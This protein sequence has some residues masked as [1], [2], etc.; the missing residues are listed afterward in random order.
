MKKTRKSALLL[1]LILTLA[2]LIMPFGTTNVFAE[3]NSDTFVTATTSTSVKQGNSGYCYV[4]IDSLEALSTLS[5]TVHYDADKVS[6]QSGYVYNT[7]SS[8]L[9]DK[10]VSESS[11]QFSYIFDGKGQNTKTQLFYFRYTVLSDSE[12]G[13]TYF[14]IVVNEAYDSSL[15][16]ITIS[17]SRCAFQIAET[18]T[19]KS[20]SA[21]SSWSVDTAVGEEFELSYSL[22]TYQIAS[23]AFSI[24]YDP[25]LFEVVGVTNGAFCNNKIVDVN[26]EL[27]GSVYVSFVGTEYNYGYDLLKVKFKTLKNVAEKSTIKMTVT[28]FYDLDLNL[29]SCSGYTTT[30]NVAFDEAYTENAPSMT[31]QTAYNAAT[32]KVTLT[33]KL[34]KDSMLGAGDFVLKFDTNY[35]TYNSAEK[36]FS[37]TFFNINDKNVSDG[38]LKFSIIS[39]SNITEEQVVL[40]V[41]FDVNHACEDKVAEFEISG[42]GLTDA[43]TN[44]IM[45]NFVDANVT[46]PLKHIGATAVVENRLE[47]TCTVD[48]RY[49]RVVY[50][51][52]C[53]TELERETNKI[54]KLGHNHST[55]WTVDIEPT[56][57]D[58]GSKSHHCS[59]C[60]NRAEV[61]AIPANGHSFGDWYTIK[62]PTCT[63]TGTDEHKCSV[64]QHTETKTT[65]AYGHTPA[66]AVVE[67]RVE[68][69]CTTNGSYDSVV[70][71]SVCKVELSREAKIINKLGHNYSTE[72]TVDI[73]PTCTTVGSKSHHCERCEDKIDIT[74]IPAKGHSFGDWYTVKA[75]TCTETGTDEHKCSVCQHTETKTTNAHGHTPANATVENIVMPSCTTNG[76][77]DSAIYCSVCNIE[78]SRETKSLNKLGHDYKTEWTVDV[79]P[80]CTT[81]GIK[82]HHCSRCEDKIDITVISANGH[83]YG[84][85]Y[86]I[87]VPT[88][89]ST[90]VDEHECS[91]CH[92]KE[93]KT[94]NALGHTPGTE[95]EEN[96]VEPTCTLNGSYD[97]VVYCSVCNSELSRKAKTINKLGH[98]YSAEWTIDEHPTC[99]TTGIKSHHCSRCD[100]QTDITVIPANGHA[101]GDWYTITLPTCASTGIDEHECSVCHSKETKTTNALGHTPADAVVENRVEPDCT[102][103]GHYES[104]VYCAV[105]NAELSRETKTL[106]KLGHNY[107]TEWTVDVK[108]TCTTTGIKSH[109]CSRCN[110]QTDM[111]VIPANGHSYGDWYVTQQSTEN[112]QGEKRRDCSNCSSYETS[113]IAVL[114]HD[115]SRWETIILEAQAPTCTLS[116]LTQ[117]SKCSKCGEILISQNTIPANGHEYGD[118]YETKAPTCITS[119]TNE[120]E[121]SV[122][123]NKETKTTNAFGHTPADAVVKN[124]VE[125]DCTTNGSYDSVVYCSVCNIELAREVKT[126]PMLGHNYSD[127]WEIDVEATCTATGSKSHH[128]TRCGDK[129][130]V[131]VIPANGHKYG[132]WYE[133]LA[134][135]C[136]TTGTNEREC[137]VCHNKETMTVNALGHT[138]AEAVVENRVK[139]DC[140]AN[141]SYDS[142]VYCSVCNAELSREVKTIPMLGHDYSDKWEIDVEA[143]CTATGS[144]SHHC[145][146][147]GDKADVTVIPANGHKYGDWYE[148][149]VPTCT[150]TGTNE[151]ECSVCHNKETKTVNALG[152]TPADAV[153]KNRVE[154]D[155]TTNG[156]YDSVVYCSVCNVELS[157]E[158]KTIPMLGHNYSEEWEIDVEAT[159]T[160]TGSKSHHCSRCDDK[161]DVTVIPANGHKYGDWRETLAPTCTTTGTNERECSVC[162]DKETKMVNALGHTPAD[163]IVENRVEADCT[164]NGHYDSVVY[165]SVCNAELSREVKTIPMLGHNYSDEWTQDS[166]PTCTDVGSKSHHCLRCDDKVDVTEVPKL[167]HAY[168]D[169]YETLA[170][171]C[172]TTGTEEHKCSVCQ[173]TEIKTTNALGHTESTAVTENRIEPTCTDNGSYDSVVYCLVCDEE[174]SREQKSID[175]LGHDYSDEWTVDTEPTCTAIGSKSHHCSRCDDKSDVTEISAIGHTY[176]DDSDATCN[177]CGDEREIETTVT[178]E[179]T[180]EEIT[181]DITEDTTQNVETE[182]TSAVEDTTQD[183]ETEDASSAEDATQGVGTEDTS[184]VETITQDITHENTQPEENTVADVTEQPTQ[185]EDNTSGKKSGCKGSANGIFVM[186]SMLL[187]A[188]A[189]VLKRRKNQIV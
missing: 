99:T 71:C 91:V 129:A 56:C 50:C 158:V 150:T 37:P 31:M 136:T 20:C 63:E 142:V 189:V 115:H 5:V 103:N 27:A 35:L 22:S 46:I 141:G 173:H 47:P 156:H 102:N 86:T 57:T 67:N 108:P 153:V 111:T 48:G 176:D 49:D 77:Y 23:G 76:S 144:K 43:L 3:E 75:P 121:C 118:W 25:E 131:T 177:N 82:S 1:T 26:K 159:C 68:P 123:H 58:M 11:V 85:W 21:Y 124:R 8:M 33:V 96:H 2:L 51:S 53:N 74:E 165:C 110:N 122:C 175:S 29:I 113:A 106:D 66:D 167:G 40:T 146:R 161:A 38:I 134:P 117:G 179:D 95:V 151:R 88:C 183:I 109:H 182:D 41:T 45:L 100:N 18:V 90:G 80:T 160:A 44:D 39:L 84:D 16:P 169:W 137:S 24:N 178:P 79:K 185:A 32:D 64:C 130:D 107:S 12:V 154:A 148:T 139:A 81:T 36:G 138:P 10:S 125:P 78:L 186:M 59:R 166:I 14:D 168:G 157:R 30:A 114:E 164:T 184:V 7:V 149:L 70:Y 135:T 181:Q 93:T 4:Y 15:Q 97:S 180:S 126:I 92:N 73:D 128:C 28:E 140:T 6:V 19:T 42:V 133:T 105:C 65:N 163:A 61:T 172:T 127:K 101:Y 116:G 69:N 120:H 145:T 155:C 13:D 62:E 87:T 147:C 170:P 171:T 174:L 89:I 104:V 52:I 132:D 83:S 17:G 9:N 112:T 162:H 55:E 188:G 119:G 143:T 98:N 60:D 94:I 54:D 187:F 34:D 72:W 152:H